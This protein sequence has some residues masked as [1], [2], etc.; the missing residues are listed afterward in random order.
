MLGL[1]VLLSLPGVPYFQPESLPGCGATRTPSPAPACCR[2]HRAPL[3]RRGQGSS[4]W[5]SMAWHI[6]VAGGTVKDISP[7]EASQLVPVSSGPYQ[8][9]CPPASGGPEGHTEAQAAGGS[10]AFPA[11]G[12]VSKWIGHCSLTQAP[13]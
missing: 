7:T 10:L 1:L 13:S 12:P 9:I 11:L 2:V 4:R 8:G 6:L 5:L 3:V